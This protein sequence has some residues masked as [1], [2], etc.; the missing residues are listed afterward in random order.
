M[1]EVGNAIAYW[2]E[3]ADEN[4]MRWSADRLT[5][6]HDKTLILLGDALPRF[7]HPLV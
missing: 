2:Y 4:G 6:S 3:F 5:R 7:P 1:F